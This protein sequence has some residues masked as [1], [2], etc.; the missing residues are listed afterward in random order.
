MLNRW[1]WRAS[2]QMPDTDPGALP[3]LHSPPLSLPSDPRDP[4][5]YSP[6]DSRRDRSAICAPPADRTRGFISVQS[7]A[8]LCQVIRAVFFL[9]V[10]RCVF[11]WSGTVVV[12]WGQV[13]EWPGRRAG[14]RG[15]SRPR[16]RQSRSPLA[17]PDPEH[18]RGGAGG[19]SLQVLVE[20]VADLA[21][22]G[23]QRFLGGL[24]LGQSS[25][26]SRRGRRC[27]GSGSG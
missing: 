10:V 19:V 26:R 21:F 23:A 2:G 24:A 12:G 14:V 16:W 9:R 17:L 13:R 3:R 5:P 8:S 1:Y 15:V 27:A 6:E 7:D 11:L 18:C 25:C 4:R 20:G 22:E